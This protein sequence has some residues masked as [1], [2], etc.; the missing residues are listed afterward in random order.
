MSQLR[1]L[2]MA[3]GTG[4]HI[5][6]AL[7]VAQALQEK[8]HDVQWL[9]TASGLEAKLIPEAGI[10]LHKLNVKGFRGKGLLAKC[11][12]PWYLLGAIFG[13][14]N[15]IRKIKPNAVL[16]FG[17]YVAAPG[18]IAAWLMRK[19]LVIHEQN[20]IAGTTNKLL[21]RFSKRKLQAFAGALPGATTV[22]NPI[23]ASFLSSMQPQDASDD[24][25]KVLVV[26]GSLGAR[27]LN[28]VMPAV[29]SK[30]GDQ[31]LSVIH[32]TGAAHG[33]T[34]EKAYQ[35]L[36]VAVDVRP[37]IKDM[38]SAYQWADL[39]VCRAGAMT[40]SEIATLGKTAIFVPYPFAIDDHQTANANYLVSHQAAFMIAENDLTPEKLVEIF[41]TMMEDKSQLETM[42]HNARQLGHQKATQ[43]V[44]EIC[45]EVANV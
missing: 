34:V 15:V 8:G 37:F 16:G 32:Q 3:G 45:E 41:K 27:A 42:Q 26:G 6:P 4:G 31:T 13:A 19:P 5:F 44:A 24:Q 29:V 14:M 21:Q 11:M 23:R 22:G 9:G 39:I 38:V 20:A 43:R 1:F 30:L 18:G 7:A 28:Q 33:E 25:F 36:G 2:I 17:G 35:A 10:E 12:A 40:V